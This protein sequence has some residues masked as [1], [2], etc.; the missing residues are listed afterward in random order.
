[1]NFQHLVLLRM[2][3]KIIIQNLVGPTAMAGI[4]EDEDN[5]S[6]P[7]QVPATTPIA[8]NISTVSEPDVSPTIPTAALVEASIMLLET[9]EKN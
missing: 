8:G 6:I 5:E 2:Q 4:L 9:P 1:M 7:T 3:M